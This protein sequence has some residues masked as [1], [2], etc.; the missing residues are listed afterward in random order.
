MKADTR[1][2]S[3]TGSY[4]A[5]SAIGLQ[6]F[7][8]FQQSQSCD[9]CIIGGGYTGL[10]TAL[11]LAERNY[12]TVLLE[13]RRIGWGASGRNGGQVGSG[14]CLSQSSLEEKFGLETAK[15]FWNLCEQA[16]SEVQNRISRHNIPCDFKKG[17][18]GVGYT[19]KAALHFR[20]E[21]EILQSNYNYPSIRYVNQEE[22]SHLL[23]TDK[24]KG[25]MLDWNSGHLHPLNFALGLGKALS[26]AGGQI[27][28]KSNVK[29]IQQKNGSY[30][31]S[32]VGG[33][34]VKAKYVVLAC[35]GYLDG[36]SKVQERH[37]MPLNSYI[38]ATE[39]LSKDT[40]DR[41]NRED[42]AV[43]DSRFSL[44]YYRLSSD[45]RLIFG[46][47]ENYTP[48]PVGNIAEMVRKRMLYVY[49]ELRNVKIDY[50]WEG[51]IAITRSRLPSFGRVDGDVYYA[52]GY[53]GHGVALA[54][55]AG[56][57][58]A[59]AIAGQAECFDVFASIR[60]KD[61]PG[62]RLLRWP[63]HV[64]A[65]VY[66]LLRDKFALWREDRLSH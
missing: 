23:G 56:K 47:A 20:E 4:Y 55:L 9:V 58:V 59:E 54:N 53:S 34:E 64:T 3:H 2:Y 42:I 41:I 8:S 19:R 66:F 17:V 50:A 24:Y 1:N 60:H 62:G 28:E 16:K 33:A 10:S 48:S 26:E 46:G 14:L 38:V 57:V 31:V 32:V 15:L 13:A 39:P 44:D 35:N 49:P 63:I 45:R 52:H 29:H 12:K 6:E 30:L 51:K 11:N 18:M 22:V 36:L 25:G 40:A 61:F 37:I 65:M 7:P 21:V 43:Y 5:A 27:F